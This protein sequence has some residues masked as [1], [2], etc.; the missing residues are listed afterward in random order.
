MSSVIEI[1]GEYK[2]FLKYERRLKDSTL[3]KVDL[4]LKYFS[5]LYGVTETKVLKAS[6]MYVF[7]EW[8]KRRRCSRG[9]Q[10][11][12]MPFGDAFLEKIMTH[13]KTFVRRMS[14]KAYLD[15]LVPGDV[16]R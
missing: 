4:S 11:K 8:L 16:P 2:D 9:K 13:I 5:E 3:R 15:K 7:Y 1:L 6:D 10:G 14:D 12:A